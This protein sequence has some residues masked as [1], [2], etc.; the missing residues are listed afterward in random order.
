[1]TIHLTHQT[2]LDHC[3]S[4][5]YDDPVIVFL[6]QEKRDGKNMSPLSLRTRARTK[7]IQPPPP[8]L[9]TQEPS[10]KKLFTHSS[11]RTI[12]TTIQS[13]NPALPSNLDKKVIHKI[14]IFSNIVM[15]MKIPPKSHKVSIIETDHVTSLKRVSIA[16]MSGKMGETSEGAGNLLL[17]VSSF[18]LPFL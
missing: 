11:S 13:R 8:P 2:L 7:K 4:C 1:M 10:T 12:P 16:F 6:F 3:S 14:H 9:I 17:R 5:T 18:W 15:L